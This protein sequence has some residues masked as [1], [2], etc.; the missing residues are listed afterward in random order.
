M[1]EAF[2]APGWN[3][4][5]IL[6][7]AGA[8]GLIP[9]VADDGLGGL[10]LMVPGLA[11]GALDAAIAAY[12]HTAH[13][14]A[15]SRANALVAIDAQAEA[16][17]R[18]YLTPGDG[19]MLSYREKMEEARTMLRDYPAGDAPAGL[20]PLMESEVGITAPTLLAVAQTV[21]DTYT[22]WRTLEAGINATRLGAKAQVQAAT[23]PEAVDAILASI[24]W[25]G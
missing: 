5:A 10:I 15:A 14:L 9:T 8:A 3:V 25:P 20:F 21:H 12:D 23:S 6:A 16:V 24:V 22:S 17:R 7:S 18:K 2:I 13:A 11:Q 4:R 1:A 19:Q